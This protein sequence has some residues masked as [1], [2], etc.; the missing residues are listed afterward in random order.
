MGRRTRTLLP[1]HTLYQTSGA[2]VRL[3]N[4]SKQHSAN[5]NKN[6]S[7][8]RKVNHYLQSSLVERQPRS[9][10]SLLPAPWSER[11]R[12]PG[13]RWSRGSRPKLILREESFVSHF[14][15]GLFA[16]FTQ[17]SQQQDRFA[18]PTTT[19]T[20]TKGDFCLNQTIR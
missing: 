18:N 14:L 15:S 13:K 5:R 12:D 11:D 4:R 16:T 7:T 20:E 17:W 2:T 19:I 9:Q 1:T 8:T 6:C 3:R 10:G